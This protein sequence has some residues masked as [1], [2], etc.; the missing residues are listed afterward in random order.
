MRRFT[1]IVFP[2]S[3]SD[4][5]AVGGTVDSIEGL[6][7]ALDGA[8]STDEPDDTGTDDSGTD[9]SGTDGQNDGANS[10]DTN[11]SN[12]AFGRMRILNKRQEGV[13]K[14]VAEALGIQY[15]NG[16]ELLEKLND[17]ALGRIA[18]SSNIPK[19]YLERMERLEAIANESHERTLK[20][21]ALAGFQKLHVDYGLDD[22]ALQKFAAELDAADKNPFVKDLDVV[23]L[24]KTMHFDDIVQARIDAAVAA[25]LSKDAQVSQHA[26]DPGA[27]RGSGSD[28][29]EDAITTVAG[30][31]AVLNDIK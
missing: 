4:D 3:A 20:E 30:L 25:A 19:E 31:N 13:L 24:Y 23:E 9:D 12:Q 7:A 18:E 15:A 16:E 22:A 6:N 10:Q 2:V 21:N 11:P 26:T 8:G 14:K 29:K 28:N 27:K 17:D 5:D 1:K